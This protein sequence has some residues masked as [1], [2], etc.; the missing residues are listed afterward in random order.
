MKAYDCL[1]K[2]LLT[3]HPAIKGTMTKIIIKPLDKV[4]D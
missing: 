3:G 2:H 1:V 4:L